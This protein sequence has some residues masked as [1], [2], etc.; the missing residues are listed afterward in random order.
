MLTQFSDSVK[1]LEDILASVKTSKRFYVK[2]DG[3]MGAEEEPEVS[4]EDFQQVKWAV[5]SMKAYMQEW[6]NSLRYLREELYKHQEG[7]LPKITSPGQMAAA[8]KALGMDKDYEVQ[9]RMVFADDGSIQET[10]LELHAK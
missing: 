9:K 1:K 6:G 7:H 2:A 8:L 10:Y 5:E 3:D 4:Y